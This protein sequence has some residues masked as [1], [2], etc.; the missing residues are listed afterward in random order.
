M[1]LRSTTKDKSDLLAS[2]NQLLDEKIAPITKSLEK[3]NSI[4]NSIDY[5]LEEL[6]KIPVLQTQVE[7]LEK[8]VETTK[9]QLLEC[10]TENKNLK[11]ALLKQELYSRKNNVKIVGFKDTK[12]EDLEQAIV[13]V[14]NGVGVILQPKDVERVHYIGQRNKKQVRPILLRVNNFKAKL[15][16]MGKKVKLQEQGIRVMEDYPE[17]IL[18]RRR[19][20]VPIF[21]KALQ[22]CPEL[23]PN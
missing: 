21:H 6:N 22:V 18:Q 16:I 13:N 7:N 20:I 1:D 8:E 4:E 9:S 3:L 12:P 11:E 19:V 2:F 23:K 5:A 15:A 10:Q 17:T 14:L